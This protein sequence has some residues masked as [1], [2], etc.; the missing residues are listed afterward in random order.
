MH[1]L[2]ENSLENF[3]QKNT[4]CGFLMIRQVYV[5]AFLVYVCAFRHLFHDQT[6]MNKK[7]VH[8]LL[9]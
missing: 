1:S 9:D 3:R 5:C 4:F 7:L 8:E 2:V 6:I